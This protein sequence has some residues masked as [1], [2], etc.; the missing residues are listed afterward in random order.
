MSKPLLSIIVPV[1]NAEDYLSETLNSVI[2][3]K[4]NS[5]MEI[6]LI[7]DG[8]SDSS[9]KICEEYSKNYSFIKLI[10]QKNQGQS[11]ARNVGIKHATGSWVTFVDSDDL[12]R[13]DYLSEMRRLIKNVNKN[14]IIMFRVKDF[15]KLA[16]IESDL[17]NETKLPIKRI[18]KSEGMYQLTVKKG[19]NYLVNK[20][21]PMHIVKDILLPIGR[22]Y[23]DLAVVYKYF[24]R[25]ANIYTCEEE[26][27]FY[28]QRVGSTT[29]LKTKDKLA[30]RNLMEDSIKSRKEQLNFFKRKNYEKAFQSA[31]FYY[32]LDKLQY[33]IVTDKYKLGRNEEYRNSQNFIRT[34]QPTLKRDG[35]FYIIL[36]IYKVNPWLIR[37]MYKFIYR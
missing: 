36:G 12:V 10:S 13:K 5:D 14:D 17:S 35:K 31:L 16:E 7:N 25:A 2:D 22:R 11:V 9:L 37:Q 15:D 6:I 24:E 34:Y 26:L 28:R 32:M 3:E 33:L 21:F 8:S 19:K 4:N 20:V 29:H 18:S 23:E 27:Y 1:Y 30:K